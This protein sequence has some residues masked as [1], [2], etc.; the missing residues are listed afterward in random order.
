MIQLLYLDWDQINRFSVIEKISIGGA[1]LGFHYGINNKHGKLTK[2]EILEILNFSYKKGVQK[3]DTASKYGNS[4]KFLGEYFRENPKNKFK[5]TTK[6][7][8]KSKSLIESLFS[9]LKLLRIRKI[10]TILF[11]SF[12]DYSTNKSDLKLFISSNKF[13][14]F[15]KIGVSIYTNDELKICLKDKNIDVIQIPFNLLDNDLKKGK[16]LK[17]AKKLNKE[18]QARSVFLQ[19]LFFKPE[20]FFDDK[21]IEIGSKLR[22]LKELATQSNYSLNELALKYVLAKEY[23]DSIVIGFD[24]IEQLKKNLVSFN[25][26]IDTK[27][28][29]LIDKINIRNED[30]LNPSVWKKI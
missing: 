17:K 25:K 11:H 15:E 2:K 3:V 8:L 30:L 6:F 24:N 9:S 18:I 29:K 12:N 4:E 23:I 16:L 13:K 27:I 28:E 7:N 20:S 14:Y 22:V 5:V 26:N 19:G 10:D 21:F 1:Q